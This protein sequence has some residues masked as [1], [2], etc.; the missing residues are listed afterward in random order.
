[1]SQVEKRT[2]SLPAEHSAYVDSKVASG[3]YASAS[4]VV[5]A[6]L[7]ALQ[8]RDDAI[9]RWLREDVAKTYDAMKKDPKRGISAKQVFASIRSP[10]KG[11]P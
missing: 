8:E 1:V 2:I 3:A 10:R 6:G 4:E 9:E 7:R 5:R 11:A